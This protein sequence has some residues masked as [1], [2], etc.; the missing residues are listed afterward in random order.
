MLPDTQVLQVSPPTEESYMR[1]RS[2]QLDVKEDSPFALS[3]LYFI[4]EQLSNTLY[5]RLLRK[6]REMM[7]NLIMLYIL[8][9]RVENRQSTGMDI[10]QL[11]DVVGSV[12]KQL[13]WE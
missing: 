1:V 8:T 9:A 5:V 3:F 6:E 2:R 10:E 12:T 4:R 11:I 7:D 13:D